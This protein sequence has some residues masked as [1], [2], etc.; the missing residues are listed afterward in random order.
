MHADRHIIPNSLT[1][2]FHLFHQT[3]TFI[4]FKLSSTEIP[5]SSSHSSVC[6]FPCCRGQ[7]EPTGDQLQNTE[8]SCSQPPSSSSTNLL[9][10]SPLIDH[11]VKMSTSVK[12]AHLNFP[13]LGVTSPD[14]FFYPNNTKTL[15]V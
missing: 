9:L 2:T 13:E 11:S 12:N 10:F 1:P 14:C 15:H 5:S 6:M 7:T 4:P 3:Q 8:H